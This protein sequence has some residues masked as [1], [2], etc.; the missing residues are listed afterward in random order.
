M[1][2]FREEFQQH[3]AWPILESHLQIVM[4]KKVKFVGTKTLCS[5]LKLL[6]TAI[7]QEK[8]RAQFKD[9]NAFILQEVLLPAMMISE[10]EFELYKENAIEYVRM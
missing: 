4:N 10:S 3:Y 2:T 6:C 5:S 1:R 8:A 9:K 7:K